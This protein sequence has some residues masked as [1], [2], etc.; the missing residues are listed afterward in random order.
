VGDYDNDGFEDL[1]ITYWGENVL[2][3]NNGDGTFSDVTRKAGCRRES[4]PFGVRMYLG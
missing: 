1:F 4:N 2:Y 3:H